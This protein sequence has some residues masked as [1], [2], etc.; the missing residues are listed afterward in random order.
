ML[1]F[2]VTIL[3]VIFLM[4]L[5]S[6]SFV[7]ASATDGTIDLVNKYA[8]SENAGWIDF[9]A[10]QGNVHI[11]DTVLTGYAYGENL[12]WISLNCSNDDTCDTGV[13]YG[14]VNN[15]EGIL[16]GYAWSENAG[17]IDFAPAEGGVT[18]NSSGDFLGY[19]YGEN[20]GWVIFNCATTESCED[21]NYKVATDW[22][23]ASSRETEDDTPP[24]SSGSGLPLG[25]YSQPEV[26]VSGF[27][28][29]INQD[30]SITANRS[31][32]LSLAAGADTKKMAISNTGDFADAAQEEYSLT[33]QW[34]L[35]SKAGGSIKEAACPNA[36]YTVYVKFYTAYGQASEAVSDSIEL[37]SAPD[38]SPASSLNQA[39]NLNLPG[40]TQPVSGQ[41][42]PTTKIIK[43]PTTTPANIF[44]QNLKYGSRGAQV[45]QLQNLLKQLGFFPNNIRSNG[46]FGP[47]T[48]KAVKDFQV[49]YN[50]AKPGVP[51]Y[52]QVGPKT[53]QALNRLNK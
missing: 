51:G 12:G 3:S 52:G 16:S 31:V 1:K 26:P 25:A 21:V 7:F 14:V 4:G 24:V 6:V 33:K 45:I 40:S 17:W 48:L 42:A 35:C 19:A 53:R 49:K 27:K 11:T 5:A 30:F 13:N 39:P 37:K 28:I 50:I 32:M 10:E 18:I 29:I 41:P 22:R 47:T 34:D 15:G 44:T 46:V 20:I 8:W 9:K 38:S 23:P 36:T 2:Y 43:Q